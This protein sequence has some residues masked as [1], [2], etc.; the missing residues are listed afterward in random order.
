MSAVKN[1]AHEIKMKKVVAF[2][3]FNFALFFVLAPH[4]FFTLPEGGSKYAVSATHAALFV[5]ANVV[6]GHLLRRAL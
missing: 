5:V 4:N 3:L 1:I 6:L 2:A